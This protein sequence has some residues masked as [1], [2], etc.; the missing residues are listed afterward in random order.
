[1]LRDMGYFMRLS[2]NLTPRFNIDH[3][4]TRQI[5]SIIDNTCSNNAVGRIANRRNTA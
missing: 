3:G 2:K 1:M 5:K 4:Y